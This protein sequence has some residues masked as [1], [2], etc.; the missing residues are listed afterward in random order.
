MPR[1]FVLFT[2]TEGADRDEYEQWARVRDSPVVRGLPAVQRFDV[3][4]ISG[5]LDGPA[6]YDY[7]EVVDVT[8]MDQFSRDIQDPE[9][10]AVVTEFG[11]FADSPVFMVSE[12]LEPGA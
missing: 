6:P 2:L 12:P 8:D 1:L 11:A 10:Q 7:V 4:R 5:T 3:H 9:M